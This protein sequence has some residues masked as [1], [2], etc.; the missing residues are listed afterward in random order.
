MS[1]ALVML[2][3]HLE[4]DITSTMVRY[5]KKTV[6]VTQALIT[7]RNC[8]EILKFMKQN[9]LLEN[10][11]I[12]HAYTTTP[13]G[14][15]SFFNKMWDH[16]THHNA[17]KS[18]SLHNTNCIPSHCRRMQKGGGLCAQSLQE[19]SITFC[20]LQMPCMRWL[21]TTFEH[22]TN[23]YKL[24]LSDNG[25]RDREIA[26]ICSVFQTN[27]SITHLDISNNQFGLHAVAN[28]C[29]IILD[30]TSCSVL[31]T[32]V[33]ESNQLFDTGARLLGEVL[34][35][36]TRLCALNVENNSIGPHGITCLAKMLLHNT[37]LEMLSLAKNRSNRTAQ[38][39]LCHALTIN[40]QLQ[41]L[42]VSGLSDDDLATTEF[43]DENDQGTRTVPSAVDTVALLL[44]CSS[45]QYIRLDNIHTDL[46]LMRKVQQ[47][48]ACHT[49]L[50]RI[51]FVECGL[52]LTA[53]YEL[54]R[55]ISANRSIIHID[56]TNNHFCEHFGVTHN[57]K[58]LGVHFWNLLSLNQ[59]LQVLCLR[60]NALGTRSMWHAAEFVAEHPRLKVLDV[61]DNGI[62]SIGAL[63]MLN[64][65]AKNKTLR[66]LDLTHNA[67]FP[68][69][70]SR[71]LSAI[72]RKRVCAQEGFD[73]HVRG[74]ALFVSA[75][76]MRHFLTSVSHRAIQITK[77]DLLERWIQD[78]QQRKVAFMLSI[79]PRLCIGLLR[80]LCLDSLQIILSYDIL[81][82]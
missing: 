12:H 37:T 26:V 1:I 65:L 44:A 53:V 46:A 17:V 11:E 39:H 31:K 58:V 40:R 43:P 5:T 4:E 33:I 18:I 81:Y 10:I 14:P 29:K 61:A 3:V 9:N 76:E 7:S 77:H 54:A 38:Q 62:G 42:D 69:S 13:Q 68:M 63:V 70:Y 64:A 34:Q 50:Q 2:V 74:I 19:M 55:G 32:L 57:E 25:L 6:S 23:L 24:V 45:V 41:S 72:I 16:A 52:T 49:V 79:H 73:L 75:R 80:Q 82:S 30:I 78:C 28:V 47:Q 51:S 60:G 71:L 35:T 21:H 27:R 59:T 22:N 15:N 36:N 67:V 48:L 20:E 8:A 56:L 66:L